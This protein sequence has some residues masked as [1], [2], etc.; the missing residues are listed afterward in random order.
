MPHYHKRRIK[1]PI[2]TLLCHIVSDIVI[3]R[4]LL[5]PKISYLI[6]GIP[7]DINNLAF[8][9]NQ[10][11]GAYDINRLQSARRIANPE[12]RWLWVMKNHILSLKRLQI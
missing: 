11:G 2:L 6:V 9:L 1:T 4:Q 12:Q 5:L 8:N 7:I 10:I 3:L